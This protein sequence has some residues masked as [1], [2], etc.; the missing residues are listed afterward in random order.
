MIL[1]PDLARGCPVRTW[2]GQDP[3]SRS[4][5]PCAARGPGGRAGALNDY[6][7]G[8]ARAECRDSSPSS[9]P[10]P[11]RGPMTVHADQLSTEAQQFNW[12]L[13]QFAGNTPEVI[14]AIAVSSDGLLIATSQPA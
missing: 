11:R 9:R 10:T 3:I 13:S 1:G 4:R 2:P 8:L 14:D 7:S 6:L 5:R 12:L